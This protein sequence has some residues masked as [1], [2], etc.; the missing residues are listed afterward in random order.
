MYNLQ[1]RHPDARKIFYISSLIAKH[2]FE[3][4]SKRNSQD[5]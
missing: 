3:V 5:N 1:K 2:M 4:F